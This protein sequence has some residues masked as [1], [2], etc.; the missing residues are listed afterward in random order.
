MT[1]VIAQ[2]GCAVGLALVSTEHGK[3]V[4]VLHITRERRPLTEPD[5]AALQHALETVLTGDEAAASA[6]IAEFPRQIS[7]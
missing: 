7:A 1:R 4:D 6:T 5:Q 2:A 3:A